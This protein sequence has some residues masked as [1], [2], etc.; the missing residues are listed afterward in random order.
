MAQ[1]SNVYRRPNGIYVVR[2][3]VPLR[4]RET[5]G[6]REVHHSTGTRTPAIAKAVACGLLAH[7][8]EKFLTLDR[9]VADVG[10][11]ALGSPLLTAAGSISLL[12]ASRLSG[13][14]IGDLVQEAEVTHALLFFGSPGTWG[15]LAPGSADSVDLGAFGGAGES[16]AGPPDCEWTCRN[17]L[18]RI[19]SRERQEVLAGLLTAGRAPVRVF[20]VP[21]FVSDDV[22]W[23][24][25]ETVHIDRHVVEGLRRRVAARLTPDQRK[26]ALQPDP[27]Q[28]AGVI[29]SRLSTFKDKFMSMR[30]E[31]VKPDQLRQIK[32]AVDLF[33]EVVEDPRFCDVDNAMLERFRDEFLPTVPNDERKHRLKLGTRSVVETV[34]KL[35]GQHYDGLTPGSIQKR[36]GW[37]AGSDGFIPWIKQRSQLELTGVSSKG[38]ATVKRT[39]AKDD[40]EAFSDDDLRALFSDPIFENGRGQKTKAGGYHD[41]KPWHYWGPLIALYSGM[42]PNESCQMLVSDIKQEN[43]IWCFWVNNDDDEDGDDGRSLKTENSRRSIPIHPRL[44]ELGLLDWRDTVQTE[45]HEKLFPYWSS[46]ATNRRHSPMA[47]RWFNDTFRKR[48]LG[49][50]LNPKRVLYSFRHNFN[51]KLLD[52]GVSVRVVNALMGHSPGQTQSE[53]TYD[54]GPPTEALLAAVTELEFHL[55][56]IAKFSRPEG[57]KALRD[58]LRRKRK[59]G[60]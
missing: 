7:W 57:L 22:I 56:A 3:V 34:E 26:K 16:P 28:V 10:L 25:P 59:P 17:G 14:P 60:A 33:I 9:I 11:I 45:G 8:R 46:H 19:S 5:I 42:R 2:L 37:L 55:P 20:D 53:R 12:E 58:A 32:D 15:H 50:A 24:T 21:T 49:A 4:H 38:A 36:M 31:K 48:A 40:R 44:I 29:V 18:L 47:S 51:T 43:G 27:A 35:R 54:K 1:V 52:A 6:K 13:L 39:R 41:F 30:G 23:L